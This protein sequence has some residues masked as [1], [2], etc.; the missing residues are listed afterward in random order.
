MGIYGAGLATAIGSGISFL[1]MMT[2]FARS[3]NTFFGVL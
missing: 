3:K 2:H 1:V